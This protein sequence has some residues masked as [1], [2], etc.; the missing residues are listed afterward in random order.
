ML[1]K[2]WRGEA[3]AVHIEI[4]DLVQ[5]LSLNILGND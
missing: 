1:D 5:Q 4:Y 2:N 3:S